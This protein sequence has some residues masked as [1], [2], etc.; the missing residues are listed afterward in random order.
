M[1]DK[2]APEDTNLIRDYLEGKGASVQQ[3]HDTSTPN[4]RQADVYVLRQPRRLTDQ[5]FSLKGILIHLIPY[6]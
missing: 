2:L 6:G 5:N 3:I 4:N 1:T